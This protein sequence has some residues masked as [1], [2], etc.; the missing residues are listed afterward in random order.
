MFNPR[1]SESRS[2]YQSAS[3]LWQH[4][5]TLM[6]L[7]IAM[8]LG[9]GVILTATALLSTVKTSYLAV[10]DHASVQDTGRYALEVIAQA[11]RQANFVPRDDPAFIDFDATDLTP[12]VI[13]LDNGRLATNSP[14]ISAPQSNAA[15]HRSDILAVRF[16]G[17]TGAA[18]LNCAGFAVKAPIWSAAAASAAI[19]A[20]RAWSIFYI[21]LD[22]AGIPELRCQYSTRDNGWNAAAV[23]RNVE[24]FHVLYGIGDDIT[25]AVE[26]YLPAVQ[27]T[28][29]QWYRVI[30]VRFALLV[31]GEH[32][33]GNET[34]TAIHRLF[35]RG[36][37]HGDDAVVTI[38]DPRHA[39][40]LR[41]IFQMTVR[42]RNNAS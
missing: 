25:G 12:G 1:Q 19:D 6:E 9:M 3:R 21:A 39:H 41:K 40:K 10:N 27:I 2:S 7:M 18:L 14:G 31:R 35:G 11:L 23:A 33:I 16:F 4:G 34:P 5:L 13:G 30:A 17:A 38:N 26:Q 37:Q 15:N 24:A 42:L 20:Q 8:M 29:Q 28:P 32:N 36:Y 22:G